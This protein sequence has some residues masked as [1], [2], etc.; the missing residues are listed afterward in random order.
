MRTNYSDFTKKNIMKCFEGMLKYVERQNI[1][2]EI[3]YLKMRTTLQKRQV[4]LPKDIYKKMNDFADQNLKPIIYD[5]DYWKVLDKE[6]WGFYDENGEFHLKNAEARVEHCKMF[7]K[8]ICDIKNKVTE[9]GM[10]E[11][12]PILVEEK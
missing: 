11:L 5:R 2:N 9:F 6:E 7:E 8:K 3:V 1:K 12:Y 4:A 10:K